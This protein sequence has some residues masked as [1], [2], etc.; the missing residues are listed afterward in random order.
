MAVPVPA[1]WDYE[2]DILVIGY[3]GAGGHTAIAAAD[4]GADVLLIEKYPS[5]TATDVLHRPSARYSGGI[6]VNANN[7]QAASDH[8]NALSF[9]DTPRPICDAWGLGAT[10]NVAYLQFLGSQVGTPLGSGAQYPTTT[11][12]GTGEF[13]N[14]PGGMSIGTSTVSGGGPRMMQ[15]VF[16][17]VQKRMAA[18][19]AA[20]GKIRVLWQTVGQ[21]LIQDD[22]TK[23]IKG[24]VAVDKNGAQ[25]NIKA[26]KATAVCTGGFEYDEVMKQN[27]LR[28]Y[29]SWF[30]TNPNN[31]GDGQ[32]MGAAVGATYWHMN[33]ISARAIPHHK[34]WIKGIGITLSLPFIFVNKLGKRWF[35]ESPWPAHNAWLEFV[36]FDTLTAQYDADPA[37]I[38]YDSTSGGSSNPTN[39]LGRNSCGYLGD[40]TTLQYWEP[41]R[42]AGLVDEVA[43]GW[44]L[45]S[46]TILDLAAQIAADPENGGLMVPSVMDAEVTKFNGYCAAGVDPQFHRQADQLKP[47]SHPPFWAVKVY[48]GGPNT[49]GGLRKNEFGQVLDPNMVPIKRLYVNGENGSC[50]GFMYP[51]GGGNICEMTI[52][53]PIIAKKMAAETSWDIKTPGA[54][55]LSL[56]TDKISFKRNTPVI[57]T[58]ILSGGVPAGTAFQ[59]TVKRPGSSSYVTLATGLTDAN[60][61]AKHTY[62]PSGHGTYY[63]SASFAGNANFLS[64]SCG[65]I[66]LTVL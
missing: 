45:K 24:A 58:G 19:T 16:Q 8:L 55:A 2:C 13:P 63:V 7:A 9:G 33:A 50:Y 59:F 6:C 32:R 56:M 21:S 66:K 15:I 61:V 30:Y 35:Y 46:Q 64:C 3:G 38:I 65:S 44:I 51:T 28:A 27:F 5:D 41:V 37:W 53:G 52:F 26:K 23:E 31:T 12:W 22:I 40:S 36:N 1:N 29:P 43:K 49:Q 4:Q 34:D 47:L 39:L 60:G 57:L 14:L 11:T 20:G 10:Q 48:P 54:T 62:K 18:P 42:S 25:L 17:N